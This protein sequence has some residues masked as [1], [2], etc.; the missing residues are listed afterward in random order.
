VLDG[1]NNGAGTTQILTTAS[2]PAVRVTGGTGVAVRG[3]GTT[4][5]GIDV[6]RFG[7][8]LHPSDTDTDREPPARQA[9][10]GG[11]PLCQLHRM[12]LGQHEEALAQLEP[13]ITYY[14]TAGM[15]PYLARALKLKARLMDATDRAAEAAEVLTEAMRIDA[16][17]AE[18]NS[19]Q[20]MERA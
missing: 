11:Q 7:L 1:T 16:T 5:R 13:A 4:G 10:D 17:I 19:T 20:S 9:V 6:E 12:V 15:P 14:E 8:L 18:R 3:E 2:S